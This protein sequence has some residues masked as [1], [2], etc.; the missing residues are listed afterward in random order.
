MMPPA[1]PGGGGPGWPT[2]GL[3]P[4]RG[5]GLEGV[6]SRHGLLSEKPGIRGRNPAKAAFS[7]LSPASDLPPLPSLPAPPGEAVRRLFRPGPRAESRRGTPAPPAR[8]P[9]P[10][11]TPFSLPAPRLSSCPLGLLTS[12]SCRPALPQPRPLDP[13][14]PP[15]F[16]CPAVSSRWSPRPSP[17]L[18]LLAGTL[19]QLSPHPSPVEF[20]YFYFFKSLGAFA[21]DLILM[22]G[23]KMIF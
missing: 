19:P 4:P 1:A 8:L 13:G 23:E 14:G 22:L 18:A 7:D 21:D 6:F 15:L 10:S 9:G 5:Q 17:A 2:P 11:E 16:F 12:R 3:G 20:F